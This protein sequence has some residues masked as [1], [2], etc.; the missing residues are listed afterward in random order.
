MFIAVPLRYTSPHLSLFLKIYLPIHTPHRSPQ[1][2]PP[3]WLGLHFCWPPPAIFSKDAE[4]NSSV[5]CGVPPLDEPSSSPLVFT[6]HW[7][8]CLFNWAL[9][10][11]ILFCCKQLVFELTLRP[12]FRIS[13]LRSLY[14]VQ[15]P[16][17]TPLC[18]SYLSP[19][20]SIPPTFAP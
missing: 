8:S 13:S 11:N 9:H 6:P 2:S 19:A 5:L 7:R 1:H 10:I 20:Q 18:L 15:P 4:V 3:V 12:L 16:H 17:V 14:W